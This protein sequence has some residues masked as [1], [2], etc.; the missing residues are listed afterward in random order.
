IDL[1]DKHSRVVGSMDMDTSGR[2]DRSGILM[3]AS[4]RM[5]E[6]GEQTDLCVPVQDRISTCLGHEG[7]LVIYRGVSG[8][9]VALDLSIPGTPT[10]P[11]GRFQAGGS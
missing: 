10:S 9:P 3:S 1:L 4:L 6:E 8:D 11:A 7:T 2:M 5:A